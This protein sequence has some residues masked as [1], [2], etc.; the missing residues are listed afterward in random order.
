MKE[1]ITLCSRCL[2]DYLAAGFFIAR[3]WSEGK[4]D[5]CDKCGRMGWVYLIERKT[6]ST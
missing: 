6:K 3:D 2:A 1:Q 4:K 5:A